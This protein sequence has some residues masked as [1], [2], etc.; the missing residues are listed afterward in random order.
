MKTEFEKRWKR[1]LDFWFSKEGEELQLCLVA[2]GYENIVFEKLMVMFGSGFSALKI[3][4]S[5][6]GQLK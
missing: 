1:E 2:Q 4:K 6:R 5:I 3:I